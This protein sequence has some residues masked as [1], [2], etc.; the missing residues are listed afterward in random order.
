M[1]SKFAPPKEKNIENAV[2]KY[3]KANDCLARKMNG[4]GFRSWPDRLFVGPSGLCLW[5]E[6][7]RPGGKVTPL[8][9]AFHLEMLARNVIVHVVESVAGGKA[10]VDR[11]L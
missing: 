7:K 4:L 8:Q 9:E 2:V 1:N 3:A 10:L 11:I 6:F 5:V